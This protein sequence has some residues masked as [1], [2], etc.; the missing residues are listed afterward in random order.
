MANNCGTCKFRSADAVMS[1]AATRVYACQRFPPL[2][3]LNEF[4]LVTNSVWCGEY[5]RTTRGKPD[6]S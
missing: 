4:P 6:P 2:G 5:S 3:K 1:T